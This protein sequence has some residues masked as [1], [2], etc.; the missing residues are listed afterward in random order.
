MTNVWYYLPDSATFKN[1][2][3][4]TGG[5]G[6]SITSGAGGLSGGLAYGAASGTTDAGLGSWS[7][8][9]TDKVLYAN[10]S[11]NYDALYAFSHLAIH[12]MTVF[13]QELTKNFFGIDKIY[14]YY[15]G[16]SEGGRDGFSQLQRYG[17]QFDGA[18]VG[19]PAMRMAFQQVIH[20]FSALVEI[21]NNYFPPTCELTRINNDTIAACD[22]LDGK[23]DGVVSRTDL[24]KLQY[25]ATV[26]IGNTY[27]CAAGGGGG[28]GPPGGPGGPGKQS[29]VLYSC[30]K[31]FS[32]TRFE[33]LI[34]S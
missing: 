10:G 30:N 1:R 28:G 18:A 24:C 12:E 32:S 4:S 22:L 21:T 23:Q 25:N 26:S 8:Q 19:A 20:L 31:L 11:M 33:T 2:F 13:G 15:S 29:S 14:S 16:C 6:F 9:L 27:A 5:G 17:S 34:G 7:A 3:L